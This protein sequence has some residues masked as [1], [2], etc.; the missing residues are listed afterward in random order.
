VGDFDG[1]GR[2]D[3]VVTQIGG[4]AEIWL[5]K[6]PGNNHWLEL[7]LRGTKS[8]RDGI[9]A[10]VKVVTSAMTQYDHMSTAGGYASSSAGPL[11][12]GLGACAA[13]DL[14]EIHWPSGIVQKLTHVAGDRILTVQEPPR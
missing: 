14:V 13:A 8:N 11:H 5:N 10:R 9:G 12:F 7:A 3:V 4:P 6:S 1:D 2:L